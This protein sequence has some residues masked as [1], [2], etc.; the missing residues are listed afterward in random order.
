MR[1]TY[2]FDDKSILEI[3]DKY[4]L[5]KDEYLKYA[6]CFIAESNSETPEYISMYPYQGLQYKEYGGRNWKK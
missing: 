5:T 1:L 6:D 2:L 3:I 4:P